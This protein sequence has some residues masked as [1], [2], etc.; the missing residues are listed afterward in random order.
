MGFFSG[1]TVLITGASSGI[2]R[3]TAIAFAEQGAKVVLAAQRS[4]EGEKLADR[5]SDNG[6]A[7]VFVSADVSLSSDVKNLVDT[8]VREFGGLDCAVNNAGID[9]T[10]G[11]KAAEYSEE[12]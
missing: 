7:A 2:G 10:R 3:S 8:C 11:I 12:T 6:G 1:K 9:G 4:V 5:I